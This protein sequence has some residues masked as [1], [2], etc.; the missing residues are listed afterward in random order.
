M[1]ETEPKCA[2]G[3]KEILTSSVW[4]PLFLEAVAWLSSKEPPDFNNL[5]YKETTVIT[6]SVIK[7]HFPLRLCLQ[8]KWGNRTA[9]WP[10]KW[11][12]TWWRT[13]SLTSTSWNS[14][15]RASSRT[16]PPAVS[17]WRSSSSS[18][19]RWESHT[20]H[21]CQPNCLSCFT[22]ACAALA[23]SSLKLKQNVV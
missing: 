19:S 21:V 16:A 4:F 14:G 23:L 1:G 17:T 5:S 22:F 9:N 6:V 2:V 20:S 11:W 7:I 10:L 3:R 15:T 18:M 13:Q 12:R 8:A